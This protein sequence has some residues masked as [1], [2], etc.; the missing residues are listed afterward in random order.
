MKRN[1]WMMVNVVW[2]DGSD[3]FVSKFIIQTER[4]GEVT[5]IT[6]MSTDKIEEYLSGNGELL[7]IDPLYNVGFD[8]ILALKDYKD[9]PELQAAYERFKDMWF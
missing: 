2:Y 3:A 9:Q 4:E 1:E 8:N 6:K 5:K 7:K